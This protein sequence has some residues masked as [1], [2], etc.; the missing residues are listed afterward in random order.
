MSERGAFVLGGSS[1]GSGK[2]LDGLG[3]AVRILSSG[4]D[5]GDLKMGVGFFYVVTP[6]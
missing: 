1:L 6:F 3:I 2:I 4:R 5:R